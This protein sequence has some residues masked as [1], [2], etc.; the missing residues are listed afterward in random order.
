MSMTVR[1]AYATL[2]RAYHPDTSPWPASPETL[3][4]VQAL[5]HEARRTQDASAP[6]PYAPPDETPRVLDVYA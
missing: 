1:A 2:L 3:A 5:Y 4:A 6:A